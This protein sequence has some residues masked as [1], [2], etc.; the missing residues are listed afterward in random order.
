VIDIGQIAPNLTWHSY[1]D[2]PQ[3]K[4]GIALRPSQESQYASGSAATIRYGL[5]I[6]TSGPALTPFSATNDSVGTA[7][8]YVRGL[9]LTPSNVHAV[10]LVR[11]DW[12][13]S[14]Y[15][16][17]TSTFT[18]HPD[19]KLVRT[20]VVVLRKSALSRPRVSEALSRAVFDDAVVYEV[21]THTT[22]TESPADVIVTPTIES[23]DSVDY[24][25]DPIWTQCNIQFRMTTYNVCTVSADIYENNLPQSEGGCPSTNEYL[26]R[27]AN[28]QSA[29]ESC[30]GEA[31][32]GDRTVVYMGG[33]D[34]FFLGCTPFVKALAGYNNLAHELGHTF[35]SGFGLPDLS[36]AGTETRLMNVANDTGT[37]LTAQE[38][39]AARQFL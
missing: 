21:E 33:F 19:V 23:S 29:V 27:A 13:G 9:Q 11:D 15:N 22:P 39:E 26:I 24:P 1:R 25:P 38:C 16:Y 20:R 36:G 37:V 32:D 6:V 8:H 30:I 4:V 14:A 12:D 7:W 31:K 5:S 35:G 10:T 3:L 2:N 17:G 28:I 34:N 18:L